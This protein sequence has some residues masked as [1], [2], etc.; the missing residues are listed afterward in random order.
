[1]AKGATK[2]ST[3]PPPESKPVLLLAYDVENGIADLV[4][5]DWFP[6]LTDINDDIVALYQFSDPSR[7]L[8][9][10]LE[11]T[12][13]VRGFSRIELRDSTVIVP[14]D[15]PPFKNAAALFQKAMQKVDELAEAIFAIRT[16][17]T[18]DILLSFFD[19][20]E[21]LAGF[22]ES[23]P[24]VMQALAKVEALE[25]KV[26]NR[27]TADWVREFCVHCQ[28]FWLEEK[29][30][31]TRIIFEQERR[32]LITPWIED[33]FVSLMR[34]LDLNVPVSKLKTVARDVPA[35][36]PLADPIKGDTC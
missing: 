34:R 31:G 16:D 4:E 6:N 11:A 30:G 15:L 5:A 18:A 19:D 2:D 21:E 23:L 32:T 22:K 24:R 26:G 1:M 25:G 9:F 10:L 29:G 8:D 36:R 28:K 7:H 20:K 12:A 27:P 35:Y 33:V 14:A 17:P 13:I 3:V